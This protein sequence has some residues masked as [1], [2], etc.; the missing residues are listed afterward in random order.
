[1]VEAEQSGRGRTDIDI[2]PRAVPSGGE[3]FGFARGGID[4]EDAT[5]AEAQGGLDGFGETRFVARGDAV[6]QDVH[7]GRQGLDGRRFVGADDLSVD[8]HAQVAL[9]FEELEKLRGGAFFHVARAD[10]KHDEQLA[11]GLVRRN[12]AH[13]AARG[14][15]LDGTAARGA[16]SVDK[17]GEE[18]FQVVVDLRDRAN[19][20]AGSFDVVRL[21]DGDGRRDALDEIDARFVHAVEELARVGRESLDVAPLSLGVNRV[22]GERGFARAARAGDDMEKSARKIQVDAAQVVLPRAADAE[23][24]LFDAGGVT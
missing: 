16:G 7:D 6:L 21:L 4:D 20:R 3:W 2:A 1:M 8:P 17:P 24:V 12:L 10:G 9:L 15:R 13:D 23:H 22:E 11:I 5:F 19:G 14:F 18:K